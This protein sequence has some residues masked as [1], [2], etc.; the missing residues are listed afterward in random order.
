MWGGGGA[1]NMHF[2]RTVRDVCT[3]PF[4]FLF[5]KQIF[6]AANLGYFWLKIFRSKKN[7]LTGK[8]SDESDE[9]RDIGKINNLDKIPQDGFLE[10]RNLET[11]E[12]H[13]LNIK[14]LETPKLRTPKTKEVSSK[15]QQEPL[16]N[17]ENPNEENLEIP[18]KENPE[19]ANKDNLETPH[20]G[21]PETLNKENL[22]TPNMRNLETPE[23]EMLHI[24]NPNAI[25]QMPSVTSYLEI[26]IKKRQ[27]TAYLE[28][29]IQETLETPQP[30]K[31]SLASLK[32]G[33]GTLETLETTEPVK[34]ILSTPEPETGTKEKPKAKKGTLNPLKIVNGSLNPNKPLKCVNESLETSETI[35]GSLEPPKTGKGSLKLLVNWSGE[36]LE[37]LQV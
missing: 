11:N 37:L 13:H 35:K 22:D 36:A 5:L 10:F 21:Y 3:S 29:F 2:S 6:F 12:E 7:K 34:E 18:D 9:S 1:A 25:E 28:T 14:D 19:T 27:T 30:M 31:I 8:D 20:K 16:T 23:E 17:L 32:I 26:L 24:S 33:K 15:H 4:I